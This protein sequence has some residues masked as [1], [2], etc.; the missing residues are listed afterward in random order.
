MHR[1]HPIGALCPPAR[2]LRAAAG[3][4]ALPGGGNGTGWPAPRHA[5]PEP[6]W[7]HTDSEISVRPPGS[8]STHPA[9]RQPVSICHPWPLLVPPGCF[10][11]LYAV[12]PVPTP[13]RDCPHPHRHWPGVLAPDM[14]WGGLTGQSAGPAGSVAVPSA[15]APA[16][17]FGLRHGRSSDA[18]GSKVCSNH[19]SQ[20]E[21]NSSKRGSDKA[22]RLHSCCCAGH[23]DWT[24]LS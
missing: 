5:A 12:R 4:T 13:S 18:L 11:R 1:S 20:G 24:P 10:D 7:C 22:A 3:C 23:W 8:K 2:P 21:Y 16:P 14:R 17:V 19:H 9:V 6:C 15:A